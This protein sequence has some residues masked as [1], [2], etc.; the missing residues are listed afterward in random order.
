MSCPADNGRFASTKSSSQMSVKQFSLSEYLAILG[1]ICLTQSLWVWPSLYFQTHSVS[2]IIVVLLFIYGIV[3]AAIS[4]TRLM[5]GLNIA[6]KLLQ[7]SIVAGSLLWSAKALQT[8]DSFPHLSDL[9]RNLFYLFTVLLSTAIFWLSNET[10]QRLCRALLTIGLI[11][12]FFPWSYSNL[13]ARTIYWPSSSSTQ[14][15][16]QPANSLPPQKTLVLLLDELSFGREAPIVEALT[17]AGLKTEIK[18]FKPAGGST[19]SAIPAIFLR[20]SFDQSAPCGISQLCSSTKVLDFNKIQTTSGSIDVIG[21]YHRYCDIRGLR[22][23]ANNPY[24]AILTPFLDISCRV[25]ILQKILSKQCKA[26]GY[27]VMK[28]RKLEEKIWTDALNAPFWN[29]GGLLYVHANAPHPMP[30]ANPTEDLTL[31]Y[32]QNIATTA[33]HVKRL[34]E[35]GIQ[36]HGKDFKLII[37]SDHPLRPVF[38]CKEASP[39]YSGALCDSTSFVNHNQIPLIVASVNQPRPIAITSILNVFDILFTAD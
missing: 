14:V 19:L 4:V 28:V 21:F 37:Y 33:D 18:A 38:W 10:W 2:A 7:F 9:P 3:A 39:S 1:F 25:P 17:S 36:K 20:A 5:F 6:R 27:A 23:C 22:H 31:E 16:T 35:L 24:P 13:Y 34:A 11:F 30:S 26:T 32:K 12:M 15:T 8:L 29:E